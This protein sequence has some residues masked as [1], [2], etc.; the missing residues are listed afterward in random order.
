MFL[1]HQLD[2]AWQEVA[3]PSGTSSVKHLKL[4]WTMR[5]STHDRTAVWTSLSRGAKFAQLMKMNW[6]VLFLHAN[7]PEG[8]ELCKPPLHLWLQEDETGNL[9][10]VF[11]KDVNTAWHTYIS[12]IYLLAFAFQ[13][14]CILPVHIGWG[15][16]V[17]RSQPLNSITQF[18]D[19]VTC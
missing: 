6:C 9:W 3:L 16:K 15:I 10:A 17:G 14:K 4:L 5:V 19:T 7:Q 18:K 13:P 11:V 8:K 2:T 1:R 12:Y